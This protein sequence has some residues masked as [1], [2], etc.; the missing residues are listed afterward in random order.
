MFHHDSVRS[1]EKDYKKSNKETKTFRIYVAQVGEIIVL[2][3]CLKRSSE[4]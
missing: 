1:I 2:N 3:P 4:Q